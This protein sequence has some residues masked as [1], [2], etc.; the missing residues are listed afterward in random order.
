MCV[1]V[2]VC[3]ESKIDLDQLAELN[4]CQIRYHLILIILFLVVG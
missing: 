1:C 2:C 3:Y 4:S